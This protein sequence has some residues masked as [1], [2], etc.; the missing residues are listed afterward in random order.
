V[1]DQEEV[2]FEGEDDALAEAPRRRHRPAFGAFDRRPEGAQ[3]EGARQ[4]DLLEAVTDDVALQGLD[5][6]IRQ[7]R[8]RSI[9]SARSAAGA[10]KM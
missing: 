9:L 7:L 10:R 8:H 1:E 2:F 5:D 6:G 4:A 3:Q